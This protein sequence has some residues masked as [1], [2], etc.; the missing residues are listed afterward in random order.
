MVNTHAHFDHAGG[1]RAFVA[2]GAT[3]VTH[4]VNKPYYE[5]IWAN[6]H[7]LARTSWQG[8]EEARVQN[9]DRESWS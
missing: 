5:K 2:E 3:I 8:S 7:T 9:R 6:P 4:E 1:L